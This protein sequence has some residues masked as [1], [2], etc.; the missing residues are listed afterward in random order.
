MLR[1]WDHGD[2]G[3]MAKQMHPEI[4]MAIAAAVNCSSHAR[5]TPLHLAAIEGSLSEAT[6]LLYTSALLH[7]WG[8]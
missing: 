2:E 3:P 5:H 7:T 4:A 6:V 1:S 8:E